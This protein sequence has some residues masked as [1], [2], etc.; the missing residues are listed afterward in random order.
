MARKYR[1]QFESEDISQSVLEG[2]IKRPQSKQTIEQSVIDYLRSNGG[3][4]RGKQRRIDLRSC[5][6]DC[7]KYSQE[8]L[9]E[10][11]GSN[12]RSLSEFERYLIG[13]E[14]KHRCFLVLRYLWAFSEQEIG[15][16][17]GISESRV[18]QVLAGVHAT[19]QKTLSK[20]EASGPL[21]AEK[22]KQ[23][24]DKVEQ[25]KR[26]RLSIYSCTGLAKSQPVKMETDNET[27]F[28]EWLT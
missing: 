8:L 4:S 15:Y 18:S 28:D 27:G 20:D 21:R 5:E 1:S 6:T 13:F 23:E 11:S 22:T 25:T 19:I 12:R 9:Y 2:Y 10:N 24:M 16:C 17:F 7:E 14:E 3:R 26:P